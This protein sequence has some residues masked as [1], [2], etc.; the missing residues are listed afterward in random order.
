MEKKTFFI[1]IYKWKKKKQFEQGRLGCSAVFLIISLVSVFFFQL[2]YFSNVLQ[3]YL[4][5]TVSYT[6]EIDVVRYFYDDSVDKNEFRPVIYT[7][8]S[9]QGSDF[10]FTKLPC[11]RSSRIRRAYIYC[12]SLSLGSVPKWLT[13]TYGIGARSVYLDTKTTRSARFESAQRESVGY[14]YM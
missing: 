2:I 1:T 8:K 13:R 4:V 11:T 10:N 6:Y 5:W 9:N 12:L 3:Y 14:I 7:E